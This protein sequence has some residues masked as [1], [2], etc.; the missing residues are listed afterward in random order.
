MIKPN[1]ATACTCVEVP[2]APLEA[3]CLGAITVSVMLL[4][5]RHPGLD[6]SWVILVLICESFESFFTVVCLLFGVLCVALG[7]IAGFGLVDLGYI[8]SRT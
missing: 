1:K 8:K 6:L 3:A 4:C 2:H 7:C 5:D